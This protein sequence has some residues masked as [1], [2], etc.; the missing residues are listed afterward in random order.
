MIDWQYPNCTEHGAAQRHAGDSGRYIAVPWAS[1]ID[2][3]HGSSCAAPPAA[4]QNIDKKISSHPV[5]T[6]CQHV[7]WKEALSWWEAAGITDV[8][9]SH[10]A[11]SGSR[12]GS[13]N[14]DS[15]AT[16]NHPPRV[17]AWPLH[18]VNVE[19]RSRSDGLVIGKNPRTKH[20]LASFIGAF[21][22]HYLTDSRCR[23]ELHE[24]NPAFF[25]RI[26][27]DAWHFDKVE[28]YRPDTDA[29]AREQHEAIRLYNEVLSESV[30]ALCPAG[31][32][33]NTIRLWEALA[34]GAVPVLVDEPPAFPEGPS[35]PQIDWTQ[36]VIQL[37]PEDIPDLPRILRA[38]SFEEI[39]ERQ[40]L[41]ID[42]YR[43]VREMRCFV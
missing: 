13:T 31:A 8:W 28:S 11:E 32:G 25:I 42:V 1:Y 21:M 33:R 24:K 9:L 34:V 3:T 19:T 4:H 36:I 39:R 23:L 10:A 16:S 18:A 12:P 27:G 30:F 38:F 22:P 43:H 20:Y 14:T 2:A 6:V 29:R 5:H 35:L 17:H 26:T 41:A 40:R 15:C 7:Y 37:T